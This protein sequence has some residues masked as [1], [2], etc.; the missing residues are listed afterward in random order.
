MPD[1]LNPKDLERL[2]AELIKYA[3]EGAS[4]D[5]MREFRASFISELKKKGQPTS[6]GVSPSGTS[7]PTSGTTSPVSPSGNSKATPPLDVTKHTGNI[8]F[9]AI[10][11]YEGF[12]QKRKDYS[13]NAAMNY[14]Q[15]DE[16]DEAK[17]KQSEAELSKL[18]ADA[19]NSYKIAEPHI[20]GLAESIIKSGKVN[21]LDKD[22]KIDLERVDQFATNVAETQGMPGR[23]GYFQKALKQSIESG[24]K[25]KKVLEDPAMRR[26][27]NN[28]YKAAKG[29]DFDFNGKEAATVFGKAKIQQTVIA[30][31]IKTESTNKLNNYNKQYIVP[32]FKTIE[33]SY[34]NTVEQLQAQASQDPEAAAI[35]EKFY[36]DKHAELSALVQQ[37]QITPEMGEKMLNSEEL[38][39]Q[40]GKA[41]NDFLGQKYKPA[42][43]AAYKQYSFERTATLNKALQF[44]NEVNSRAQARYKR[45]MDELSAE[46]ER[47]TKGLTGDKK[48][49]ADMLN[50]AFQITAQDLNL[51]KLE[52]EN[53]I[54]P[55][56]GLAKTAVSSFA[57]MMKTSAESFGLDGLALSAEI[58]EKDWQPASDPT[59][60]FK[61]LFNWSKISRSTGQMLGSMLPSVIVGATV[62]A[63]TRG[64][65]LPM[66]TRIAMSGMT[67]FAVET[68]SIMGEAYS[69]MLAKTGSE[70]DAQQAY[71]TAFKSQVASIPLYMVDGIKFF[72]SVLKKVPVLG[73]TL[74][75]RALTGALGSFTEELGQEGFQ[76]LSERAYMNKQDLSH[77]FDEGWLENLEVTALNIVPTL[78]LGAGGPVLQ[79]GYYNLTGSLAARRLASSKSFA[80][81]IPEQKS[82]FFAKL[83]LAKSDSYVNVVLSTMLS[84]GSITQEEFDNIAPFVANIGENRRLIFDAKKNGA[85]NANQLFLATLFAQRDNLTAKAE[86]DPSLQ[87]QIDELNGRI[88]EISSGKNE[89]LYAIQYPDNSSFVFDEK[90]YKTLMSD[91]EFIKSL[92]NQDVKIL[93]SF[94]DKNK[95][96]AAE[97][98]QD[99]ELYGVSASPQGE[100]IPKVSAPVDPEKKAE[101]QRELDKQIIA[102]QERTGRGPD[103]LSI[104]W[105]AGITLDRLA[106]GIPVDLIAIEEASN[107]LYQTYKRYERMLELDSRLM[108]TEQI[109]GL[110]SE[111]EGYITKLE[112]VKNGKDFDSEVT[113]EVVENPEQVEPGSDTGSNTV[114][115]APKT[116]QDSISSRD[117]EQGFGEDTVEGFLGSQYY[118]D[119]I[120]SAK[121]EGIT[122]AQVIKDLY[123]QNAF[124][125]LESREDLDAIEVQLKRDL[126]ADKAREVAKDV[127]EP[128]DDFIEANYTQIVADLKLANKIKT[129]GCSY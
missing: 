73:K 42:F 35:N 46:V 4:D 23:G 31:D 56:S 113:T 68:P 75:G 104:D 110:M 11:S 15:G 86:T 36:A 9:N 93:F 100:T 29:K 18:E 2:K 78:G 128:M 16:Y 76:G 49:L 125:N 121:A 122:A 59:S 24:L 8:D 67:G 71:V 58:I 84:S 94:N 43:E 99:Q 44:Q 96:N 120:A 53:Q 95:A 3:S 90:T 124:D 74:P 65:Q 77:I 88:A 40:A 14:T 33:T 112:N 37:G 70:A 64:S 10:R 101:E 98:A 19:A 97:R 119:I 123:K 28:I 34:K 89:N 7:A 5:D 20:N 57:H 116:Y 21:F 47:Q 102:F 85:N 114:V 117:V 87:T 60:E 105:N 32:A 81:L 39:A 129:K 111:L 41:V 118:A 26:N 30:N 115:E 51:E 54:N 50:K 69:A 107:S 72:P 103:K 63:A 91:P 25:V 61:D 127:V 83:A 48:E 1:Q 27:F 108:T 92:K 62:A 79:S 126:A 12:Q 13:K 45:Q 109:K 22:G 52:T 55:F 80:N 17:V 6:S 66:A 106:N 82:Q 38:K